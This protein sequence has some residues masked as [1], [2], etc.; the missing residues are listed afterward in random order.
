[1]FAHTRWLGVVLVLTGAAFLGSPDNSFAQRG[2]RG[3]GG[4]GGR[5]GGGGGRVSSFSGGRAGGFSGSRGYGGYGGYGRGNYGGYGRGFYGGYGLGYG[6]GYG[7]YGYGLGYGGYWPDYSGGYYN[8]PYDSYPYSSNSPSYGDSYY[9]TSPLSQP[10]YASSVPQVS[11]G[12]GSTIA[13]SP[14]LTGTANA[15]QRTAV[16]VMVPENAK[17]W[18]NNVQLTTPGTVR[19]FVTPPLATGRN[20]TYEVRAS[21]QQDGREVSQTQTVAVTPGSS[22]HL[23]FPT[24]AA[25]GTDAGGTH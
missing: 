3:G 16:T 12:I 11:S 25:V 7:G 1:M 9:Y 5:G 2:G 10:G 8:Y 17:L 21:W 22:V 13:T 15:G 19:D 6:L 20:Y 23:S 24:G 14:N 18:F 4:G